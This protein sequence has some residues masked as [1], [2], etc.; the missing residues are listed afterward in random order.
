[1]TLT[2]VV[3]FTSPAGASCCIWPSV[4]RGP[5]ATIEDAENS[6]RRA[7]EQA[8]R[9]GGTDVH[10]DILDDATGRCVVRGRVV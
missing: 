1:M 10:Y 8:Q 9:E 3:K 7:I 5:N 6:L 2:P 4:E